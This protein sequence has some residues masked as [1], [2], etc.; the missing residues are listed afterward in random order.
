MDG[1]YDGHAQTDVNFMS[2]AG[3][4]PSL[5]LLFFFAQRERERDY[6]HLGSFGRN[7]SEQ[8]EEEELEK[9]EGGMMETFLYTIG[10]V[11]YSYREALLFQMEG[12]T[13]EGE[14]WKRTP[15]THPYDTG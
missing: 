4:R 12:T 14:G 8:R 3:G 6:F 5:A 15:T 10:T 7:G 13:R 9:G 1:I 2:V 11:A